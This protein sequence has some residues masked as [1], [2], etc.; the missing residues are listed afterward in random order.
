MKLF[1]DSVFAL[2]EPWEE[3]FSAFFVVTE[4]IPPSTLAMHGYTLLLGKKK[5]SSAI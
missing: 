1:L 5:N 2:I 4:I 3:L